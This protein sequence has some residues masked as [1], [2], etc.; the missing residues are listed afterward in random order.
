M[1]YLCRSR[2][3]CPHALPTLPRRLRLLPPPPT[4]S[5]S[6]LLRFL[7]LLAGHRQLCRV[8]RP[9]SA[10]LASRAPLFKMA[11]IVTVCRV[12][13]RRRVETIP[14]RERRKV[15]VSAPSDSKSRKAQRPMANRLQKCLRNRPLSSANA[16]KASKIPPMDSPGSARSARAAVLL[17]ESLVHPPQRLTAQSS[18]ARCSPCW[19]LGYGPAR[20]SGRATGACSP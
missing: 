3:R 16:Q 8:D 2:R 13:R 10:P 17:Q 5:F 6:L 4:C 14:P 18:L 20:H 19:G 1:R 11:S 7:C 9:P 15:K 12:A